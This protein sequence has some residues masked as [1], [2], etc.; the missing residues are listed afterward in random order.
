[1]EYSIFAHWLSCA[2]TCID[3]SFMHIHV[4]LRTTIQSANSICFYSISGGIRRCNSMK[5]RIVWFGRPCLCR[6]YKIGA[7]I[8][9]IHEC[10]KQLKFEILRSSGK[11]FSIRYAIIKKA[12]TSKQDALKMEEDT[13]TQP[14]SWQLVHDTDTHTVTKRDGAKWREM[15]N[16]K[17]KQESRKDALHTV[18]TV[19]SNFELVQLIA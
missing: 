10:E 14:T 13:L 8:S 6:R 12:S 11:V 18:C 1:M 9:F 4:K 17:T 16:H 2:T 5:I 3:L 15:E 19:F 7:G